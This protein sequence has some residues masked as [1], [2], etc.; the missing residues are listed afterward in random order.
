MK[1]TITIRSAAKSIV[2]ALAGL[3]ASF[4]FSVASSSATV[5]VNERFNY[6]SGDLDAVAGEVWTAVSSA[7][8]N[9]IHVI[10]GQVTGM[11]AGLGAMEDVAIPFGATADLLFYGMDISFTGTSN[12]TGWTYF[13]AFRNGLNEVARLFIAAP[14]GG[15]PNSFRLGNA[16]NSQGD[17]GTAVNFL[18]NLSFGTVYRVV[19]SYNPTVGTFEMKLY[20]GSTYLGGLGV[21]AGTTSDIETFVLRQGGNSSNSYSGLNIDNLTIA[22]TF[23]EAYAAVPEPGTWAMMALGAGILTAA[24]WRRRRPRLL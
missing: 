22:T 19:G 2:A 10:D 16:Q 24:Q 17:G 20:Q 6:I 7:G 13:A 9:P 14:A 11:D 5:L 23:D 8:S 12:P 3:A 1:T 4:C 21:L 15:A 18:S